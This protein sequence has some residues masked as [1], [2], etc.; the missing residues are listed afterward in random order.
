M[1]GYSSART[2]S[3]SRA[4]RAGRARFLWWSWARRQ[5]QHRGTAPAVAAAETGP[6][7]GSPWRT[8]LVGNVLNPK[9]AAFCTGLLPT[10]APPRLP[11]AWAKALLVLLHTFLTLAWLGG[12][13]LLLSKAGPVLHRPASTVRSGGPRASC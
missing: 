7:V 11:T 9:N 2:R 1:P 3:K 12:Y 5:W 6:A 8:G 10:L 13:V 4:W